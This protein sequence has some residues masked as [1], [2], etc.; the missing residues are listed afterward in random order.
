MPGPQDDVE[1]LHSEGAE[2]DAVEV[3]RELFKDVKFFLHESIKKN[4]SRRNL[5]Q[6]I[7][8]R[9]E[10]PLGSYPSSY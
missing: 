1:E 4:F 7:K 8:V 9:Y 5:T 6:D 3:N 10:P 2:S